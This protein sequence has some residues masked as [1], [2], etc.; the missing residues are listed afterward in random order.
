MG[1]QRVYDTRGAHVMATRRVATVI[2]VGGLLWILYGPFTMLNPWGAD[3]AYREAQGYSV[4]IDARLFLAYSLPGALALLL[5]AAGLLGV[6]VRLG[7]LG[8]ALE[9][10]TR[11]LTYVALG[12]GLVSLVGVVVLFDPVF[13]AGR[14]FGTLSLG[15]AAVLASVMAWRGGVSIIWVW[16]LSLVGAAGLFLLP[17]WPLVYALG[18]L[19]NEAGAVVIA[20][21]GIGWMWAGWRL[22]AESKVSAVGGE[23]GA[24][25]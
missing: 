20:L 14:I 18:W 15:A 17:L 5:T 2:L 24:P 10:I 19:S 23:P 16:G 11:G 4:I 7:R 13:T 9:L 22:L 21:F 1:L 25:K 8:G 12:L 6:I 3:V